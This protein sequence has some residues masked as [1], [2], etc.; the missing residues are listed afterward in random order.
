MNENIDK[1]KL[2]ES[3]SSET[4][5]DEI[6]IK[7]EPNDI[8]EKSKSITVRKIKPTE[9]EVQKEKRKKIYM[10]LVLCIYLL[11]SIICI[12][13]KDQFLE[14]KING[15]FDN[16]KTVTFLIF[17]SSIGI[18]FILS[19]IICHFDCLIKTHFFG[20]FFLLILGAF[21][22]YSIIYGIYFFKN[23]RIFYSSIIVL[24]SGSL[25]LLL[26]TLIIRHLNINICYL[27][28]FNG[29]FSIG[30]TAVLYYL[31]YD[32]FWTLIFCL[33]SLMISLF[34]T[35][36]SLYKSLVVNT[37]KKKRSKKELKDT[38]I[39][40]QP[41]ELNISIY[42]LLALLISFLLILFKAC[43]KTCKQKNSTTGN[44]NVD[45]NIGNSQENN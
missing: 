2:I 14:T 37:G 4:S 25:G 6:P 42:K 41:F 9:N 19:M 7:E 18:S 45:N 3:N 20:I 43:I 33:T 17:I 40:S 10:Y 13:I 34:N 27:L 36:S 44:S 12:L 5:K 1:E 23:F 30:A 15:I 38:L 35:Y 39:Y 28:I 32:D 31:I 11:I 26:L 24:A 16:S 21:N 8:R 29:I 22:N